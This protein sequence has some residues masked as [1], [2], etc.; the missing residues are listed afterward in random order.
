MSRASRTPRARA[1]PGVQATPAASASPRPSAAAASA[2]RIN[3]VDA[4]RGFALCLMFVYHFAFDLRLYG[5]TATDF[6]HDPMWLGFRAVI[7]ATFMGLVGVSLGLAARSGA[8]AR[9]FWRRVALIAVCALLVSLA[10]W[11]TFPRSFIY[12]GV[13][14]CI[15]I[16]SVLAAPF[17]RWP[18]I[19]LGIGVVLIIAGLTVSHPVFDAPV[20][21][22]LGFVTQKP[23]TDDYVPI[24]PWAGIVFIGIAFGELLGRR[25]FRALAPLGA[26]PAPLRWLGRHSLVVYMVHQPILLGLLWLVLRAG[27]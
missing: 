1:A 4:L 9:R 19:S 14:H 21:S 7:V 2:A 15:A 26:A 27:R 25:S 20:L 24:A 13:L 17:V 12:F 10:S 6:E 18:M 16:A 3:G 5:V 11:L 22:V 23:V 8:S